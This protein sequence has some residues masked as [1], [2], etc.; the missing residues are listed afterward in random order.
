[1]TLTG[2]CRNYSRHP[3]NSDQRTALIS[4]GLIPEE[5][6]RAPFFKDSSDLIKKTEGQV[7]SLVAPMGLLLEALAADETGKWS[8]IIVD[9]TADESA[10]KRGCF[11]AR[12]M[13]VFSIGWG[14]VMLEKTIPIE[15]TKENDFRTGEELLYKGEAEND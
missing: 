6:A 4:V 11:A 9:W 1:M 10:R 7:A 15:P 3:F 14:V 8:A 5:G 12:A 2:I 13:R